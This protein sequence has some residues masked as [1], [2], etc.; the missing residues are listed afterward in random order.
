MM[1]DVTTSHNFIDGRSRKNSIDSNMRM[2]RTLLNSYGC[3]TKEI[4]LSPLASCVLCHL[5]KAIKILYS[6]SKL[7]RLIYVSY[8]VSDLDEILNVII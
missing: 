4:S 8:Y 6:V 3:I 1:Q 5:K 7:D 2:L